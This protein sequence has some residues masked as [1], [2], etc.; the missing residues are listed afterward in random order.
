ALRR[1]AAREEEEV[2][3]SRTLREAAEA[4]ETEDSTAADVRV[5]VPP[6]EDP[7]L[8]KARAELAAAKANLEAAKAE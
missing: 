4:Q 1:E 5:E 8:A 6:G 2:K 7:I 3:A